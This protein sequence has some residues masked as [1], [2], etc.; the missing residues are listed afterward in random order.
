MDN[1]DL[2]TTALELLQTGVV[3]SATKDGNDYL[4]IPAN[5]QV[6]D[7]EKL[8]SHPRRIKQTVRFGRLDSFC[9]YVNEF[10]RE[11]TKVFMDGKTGRALALID[12]HKTDEPSWNQHSASFEPAFSESW[13]RWNGQHNQQM[14][15]RKFALFIEDNAL[16]IVDPPPAEMLDIA[17][18]LT[19]K[20]SV[21]FKRGVH[22]ENGTEQLQ[23]EE[24]IE[25]KVGQKGQLEIPSVFA[26]GISVFDG[27]PLRRLQVRL[28]YSIK[29]GVL[30][31]HYFLMRLQDILQPEINQIAAD[32]STAT[33]I[34]PLFGSVA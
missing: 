23:Y 7:L 18:N 6:Y 17:R 25:T 22:L 3:P 27:R 8:L 9:A 20:I 19:A 16:D 32:I 12:Y 24:S 31:F 1:P 29:E 2:L 21:N 14:D 26:L 33:E 13:Q 28:R 4:V 30:H 11:S 15:Q 5:A 10:K 34:Q